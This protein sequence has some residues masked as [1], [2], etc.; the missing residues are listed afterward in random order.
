MAETVEPNVGR[1]IKRI[2]SERGFSLRNLSE[3]CN[4]SI[5]AISKIERGMASPTV[6]S[7]HQIA[8]ALEIHISD[9]FRQEISE[10]AVF[11]KAQASTVLR[12]NG[13]T[14]ESLGSGL[15]NQQLEPFKMIIAPGNS[16]MTE[17]VT[18][19]GE[20]YI[21]C[22]TG[23]V[24]YVVGEKKF[25]LEAGDRLLFKATQPHCWCNRWEEPAELILVMETDRDT[26]LPYQLHQHGH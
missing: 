6:S 1:A 11:V 3:K 15:P 23:K 18:H 14:I 26:P 25:L 5:N 24:E 13:L 16:E 8:S 19:A 12:S 17:P 22:L 21:Y 4:L 10:Y 9:F 7:L 20:E 2:R